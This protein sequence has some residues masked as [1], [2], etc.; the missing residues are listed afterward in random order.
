VFVGY[1]LVTGV[2]FT[3]NPQVGVGVASTDGE[4]RLY[5]HFVLAAGW[6]F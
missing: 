2:G 3:L 5:P 4:T 1:K 6:S